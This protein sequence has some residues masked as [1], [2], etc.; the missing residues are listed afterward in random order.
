MSN[1]WYTPSKYIEAARQVMGSIDL[2]PASCEMANRTVKAKQYYSIED[3]GLSKAWHGNVWLNPPYGR[4]K[5]ERTGSTHS[6]QKLFA[7]KLLKEFNQGHIEQAIILSLGNP[8][9]IW[10]QPFFDF[11]LCFFCGH[12]DFHCQDGSIGRFGFPNVFV[13]LGSNTS[14]FIEHF[15]LFGRIVKAIDTPKAKVASLSLWEAHV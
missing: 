10:F 6:F 9:S 8:N 3:N 13:Y 12:I 15:S 1:E 2:D 14:A 5:P 11:P 7:Q 4:L